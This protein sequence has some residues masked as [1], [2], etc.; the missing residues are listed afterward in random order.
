MLN[1]PQDN[2][3]RNV[4][5]RKLLDQRELEKRDLFQ[6]TILKELTEEY[7]IPIVEKLPIN[8]YP[9]SQRFSEYSMLPYGEIG[10]IKEAGCGIFAVEYAFR[11]LGC[12]VDF[13][14]LLD[15]CV[16]KGYRG[17][18]LDEN[19]KIIDGSGTKYSLFTN[20]AIELK[21]LNQIFYFSKEGFPIT[22]LVQNSVYKNESNKKGNHYITLVGFAENEKALLMDGNRII[23]LLHPED[24]LLTKSFKILAP[25]LRGAWAWKKEKLMAYL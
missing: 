25:G 6:Q 13:V 16:N 18:V 20:L 1:F 4:N 2:S 24:A 19:E 5:Q 15:E 14:E 17:Y 3:Y 22:L 7:T 11:L 12:N 8:I 21:H 23:N 10:I 9:L